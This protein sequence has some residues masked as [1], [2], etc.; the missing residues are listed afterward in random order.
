MTTF[1]HTFS[2]F[3]QISLPERFTYPFHY[4]PHP[5][6]VQAAEEV[7]AYLQGRTDWHDELQQGKM[8]GV[9]IVRTPEGAIGYLAA[10]SGNLAGSNHHDYFVPPVYDLLDPNGYFKQEEASISEINVI[11]N[12]PAPVIL[13]EVKDLN[14]STIVIQSEAKNLGNTHVNATEILRRDAPLDDN[15]DNTNIERLK[16]ERKLR[17]IALQ[18]WIFRQFRLRN[19]RGEEK[20]IEQIFEETARRNPPAGTGECAAPK[21][22]Q[23]AYLQG[24]YPLAMAEF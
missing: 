2:N 13:N 23:H 5:L 3:E 9:L 1:L 12:S 14:T 24:Y 16:E 22:L 7:Q 8:F 18:Q 19:V 17:S 15:D 10:F 4:T 21:L 6:C 11:L 20:D